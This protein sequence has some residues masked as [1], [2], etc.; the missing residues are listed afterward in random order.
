LVGISNNLSA[1]LCSQLNSNEIITLSLILS[2]VTER[3]RVRV[4]WLA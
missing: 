2:V 1:A 3:V 4:F